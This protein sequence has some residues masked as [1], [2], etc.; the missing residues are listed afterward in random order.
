MKLEEIKKRHKDF[1]EHEPPHKHSICSMCSLIAEVERLQEELAAMRADNK[2]LQE[3]Q[4]Y[5][6]CGG[7]HLAQPLPDGEGQPIEGWCEPSRDCKSSK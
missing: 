7:D 6:K 3:A 5:M 2:R 4:D 1:A